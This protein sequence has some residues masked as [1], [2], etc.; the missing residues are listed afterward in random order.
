MM[1]NH[2]LLL[3]KQENYLWKG[4]FTTENYYE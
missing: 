2:D 3:A 4:G 1:V